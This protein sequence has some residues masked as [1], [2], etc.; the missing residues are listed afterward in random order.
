[1]PEVRDRPSP[2]SRPPVR[3]SG[4]GAWGATTAGPVRTP[5]LP[6]LGALLV[7]AAGVYVAGTVLPGGLGP[8]LGML[9]LGLGAAIGLWALNRPILAVGMLLVST[10]LSGALKP[11][12]LPDPGLLSLMAV[13]AAAGVGVARRVSRAPS[14]GPV[15]GA[16]AIYVLW[17][18]ASA[19]TPHP[20]Q[21][22]GQLEIGESYSVANFVLTGTVMPFVVYVVGRFLFDRVDAVR[23]ILW[24]VMAL[25]A[26]SV[27]VSIAQFH[28]PGLVWPRYILD[29]YTE[30]DSWSNRAV[31]VFSQP[32]ANGLLLV[33]G[34]VLAVHMFHLAE[35]RRWQ[36]F[37]LVG[38]GTLS[39]YA[40]YLT[41]TRVVWLGFLVAVVLM[42]IFVPRH[43][44]IYGTLIGGVVV[45]VAAS[46]QT[47][48]SEDRASGGITS[49]YEIED[50]LNMIATALWAIPQRPLFGWGIGT[51]SQVNTYHHQQWSPEVPWIRG[52]GIASHLT[53]LGIAAE[54][55]LIG[56]ALWLA[57][58][59]LVGRTLYR[60]VRALPADGSLTGREFGVIV[61]ILAVL[62]LLTG[63]TAD[64]R[65]F[66]FNGVLIYLLVGIVVG[67]AEAKGTGTARGPRTDLITAGPVRRGGQSV[68]QPRSAPPAAASAGPAERFV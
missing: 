3:P 30:S 39:L 35:T 56:L 38:L 23:K 25:F 10:F 63:L 2:P 41:H 64:V 18:I 20:Y 34:F 15:E 32:V 5:L 55:G 62:W 7:V 57:V 24:T 61:G 14:F 19:L 16:M 40:I 60:A 13:V 4:A 53:E 9:G 27:W 58:L 36:R 68:R 66:V 11:L 49:S 52:Y 31:G 50:R 67:L 8:G 37:L 51:F 26:Y 22:G 47:L 48:L 43:R 44:R 59:A 29:D 42:A 1:V 21:A 46:W 28:L 12:P 33:T 65:F 17:I 6:V 45:A 54:L